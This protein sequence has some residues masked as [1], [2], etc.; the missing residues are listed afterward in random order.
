MVGLA[1][2]ILVMVIEMAV[3]PEKR[4]DFVAITAEKVETIRKF[5]GNISFDVVIDETRPDLVVYVERWETPEQQAA[6]YA[7]WQAQGMTDRLRPYVT[8][9]PKVAIYTSAAG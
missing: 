7:W 5:D 4:D 2:G 8:S 3:V 6:F 1:A 9:A